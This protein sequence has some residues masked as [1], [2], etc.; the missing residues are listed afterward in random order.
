MKTKKNIL[1]LFYLILIFAILPNKIEAETISVKITTNSLSVRSA[2][3]NKSDELEAL[4][5]NTIINVSSKIYGAGCPKGWYKIA[6]GTY[7]GN[8]ICSSYTTKITNTST[9]NSTNQ[10]TNEENNQT[11]TN[12]TK[13][14]TKTEPETYNQIINDSNIIHTIK[15]SNLRSQPTTTSKVLRTIKLNKNLIIQGTKTTTNSGCSSEKWYKVT[16]ENTTG[17]ICSSNVESTATTDNYIESCDDSLTINQIAI[18]RIDSNGTTKIAIKQSA[19]SNSTSIAYVSAGDKFDLISETNY[20]Y[21]ISI[22]GTTGYISK[23][24]A[25]KI[26]KTETFV[27]VNLSEN[28]LS[29]YING[30]CSIKTSVVTGIKDQGDNEVETRK[31][32]YTIKSKITDKYF[33]DSDVYSNYWMPFDGGIGLH[34]A[35][36]WRNSY[37]FK[38]S[39]GCVNIPLT[40]TKKIYENVSVGTKVIVHE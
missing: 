32:A 20:Y 38:A 39:H 4:K 37:G 11:T 25:L 18:K 1:I 3:T 10:T 6:D 9:T 29:L 21:Q 17:Y 13:T 14:E 33:K 28:K 8:Y 40:A 36:N 16:F 30:K 15:N 5:K 35:D 34:D 19:S 7:K 12:N 2:A 27:E 24:R 26:N 31:G 23:S 22:N